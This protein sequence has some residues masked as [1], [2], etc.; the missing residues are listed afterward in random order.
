MAIQG[1][2]WSIRKSLE[3]QL[4]AEDCDM[5]LFMHKAT[6]VS[7]GN[8]SSHECPT[9]GLH[10]ARFTSAKGKINSPHAAT[11]RRGEGGFA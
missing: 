4:E 2:Y 3:M 7:Y 8:N 11:E 5:A 9:S 6:A 10:F 1:I